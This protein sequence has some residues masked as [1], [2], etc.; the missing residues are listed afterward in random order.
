MLLAARHRAWM[1][2]ALVTFV[3]LS[4]AAGLGLRDP[5]PPD[6]PRFV[7]AAK[8]MVEGGQ[9]LLPH[10]G[11]EYYAEK[12]ATFMWLQAIAFL[13]VPDWRV[14]FLLPSLLAALGTLYLTWDLARRLW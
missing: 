1:C 2:L 10:R 8:E 3:G 14:A 9:W 12:P 4:L 7:L 11:R 13:V 5:S 6:E